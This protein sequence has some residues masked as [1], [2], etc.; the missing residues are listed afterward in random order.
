[1]TEKISESDE[2]IKKED[3]LDPD[4]LK[5]TKT[6]LPDSDPVSMILKCHLLAEFYLDRLINIMMPRGDIITESRFQFSEKLKIIDALDI[7]N[8]KI[9]DSLGKLN[10][11]RN[12]CSHVLDYIISE[13][14]IEKLGMCFR[15][16]YLIDKK[17]HGSD[18]KKLLRMVLMSIMARTTGAV[19]RIS[20][21]KLEFL[22]ESKI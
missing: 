17:Q 8:K 21:K 16:D 18:Q 5:F 4:F 13:T 15:D 10:S 9:I 11:I 20:K 3:E 6:I 7:L 19:R 12:D 1:M 22:E 2:I 14:D